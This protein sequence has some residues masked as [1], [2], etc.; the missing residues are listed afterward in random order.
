LYP[1]NNFKILYDRETVMSKI[2]SKEE[3]MVLIAVMKYIVSTDGVITDREV[4]DINKLAEEKG[5]EDFQR[6]FD[7][8][9][10][11]VKSIDDLKKLID[12]VA[13]EQAR[14]NILKHALEFSRADADINPHENE[15]LQYMSKKWHINIKSL[16]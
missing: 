1:E 2:L 14:T 16:L 8:V 9:D 7:E 12:G 11:T 4:D 3:K 5:F 13:G 10:R 15:I 6:T